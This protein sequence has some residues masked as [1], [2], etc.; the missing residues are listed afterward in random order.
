RLSGEEIFT[1]EFN[2]LHVNEPP[3]AL[4]RL[5]NNE[6]IFRKGML[7]WTYPTGNPGQLPTT[8]P[9]S[10]SKWLG[11]IGMGIAGLALILASGGLATPGVL[12]ALGVASAGFSIASTLAEL[13]EK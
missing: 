7:Y 13:Q 11:V 6:L 10:V 5:L 8:E 9:W 1:R 4:F 12:T 3:P 2:H